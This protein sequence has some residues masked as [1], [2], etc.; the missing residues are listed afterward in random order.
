MKQWEYK[1]E[2]CGKVNRLGSDHEDKCRELH[3]ICD[4]YNCKKK[5]IFIMLQGKEKSR[6]CSDCLA[7]YKKEHPELNIQEVSADS[8]HD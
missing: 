6:W 5:G 1:C 2:F 4:G 8:S 3:K 7:R